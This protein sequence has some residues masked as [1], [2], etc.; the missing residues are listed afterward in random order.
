MSVVVR[1]DQDGQTS[2]ERAQKLLAG[3]PGG[4]EKAIKSAMPRA[5]SHLRTSTAKA[6][7]ERYDLST[8]AIRAGENVTI[9]YAFGS[10]VTAYVNFRGHKIPLFRYGG[11]SP[12]SPAVDK[13]KLISAMIRGKWAR[14]HP[15]VAASGHQLRGT[16]PTRFQEA[17]VARMQSGHNGIFERT[18]GH[19][20]GGGDSIREIMG[21]SVPQMIGHRDVSERLAEEAVAKFDDRM[22]HEISRILNGWG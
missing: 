21:S 18:G 19:T 11:A 2:L 22:D 8:S 15:G 10:G 16:S 5:V 1:V 13:D 14:V 6:V 4:V 12:K 9:K 7:Q 17:F 20:S 3:I